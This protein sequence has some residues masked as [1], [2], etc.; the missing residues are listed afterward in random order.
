MTKKV[1]VVGGDASV[2]LMFHKAGWANVF[3]PSLADFIC[4]TGGADVSPELYGQV[5]KGLSYT[6]PERDKRE[7]ALFEQ[8]RDKKFI[9]I[10]RGGQL[11]NVLSGGSMIQD[12][13]ESHGGHR[14]I[15]FAGG[16][17]KKTHEDHH[18][19]MVP[20]VGATIVAMDTSD[21]NAEILWYKHT[22]ALC[23]QAHPEWGCQDT[24]HLFFTLIEEYF[25]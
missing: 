5:N 6:N 10:C 11:L 13:D 3:E 16:V 25:S 17:F 24:E 23:F 1:F 20:G 12:L 19:G 15:A 21:N 9:G 8:F 14:A 22:R 7:V 2:R 4:F 18:Q